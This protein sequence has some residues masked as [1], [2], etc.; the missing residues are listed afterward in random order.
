M[1]TVYIHTSYEKQKILIDF[2]TLLEASID[3]RRNNFT[4]QQNT[5]KTRTQQEKTPNAQKILLAKSRSV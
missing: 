2:H 5:D 1:L 3:L 4:I